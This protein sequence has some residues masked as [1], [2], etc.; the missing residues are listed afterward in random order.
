MTPDLTNLIRIG[1][2]LHFAILL[3]GALTPQ[4][5]NWKAELRK[6]H[7]MSR[8]IIWVHGVFIMLTIIGFGLIATI[9][10]PALANGRTQLA[11]G[12]C[13]FIAIFWAIRFSLQFVL[14]KPGP[15]HPAEHALGGLV[16]VGQHGQGVRCGPRPDHMATGHLFHPCPGHLPQAR[17]RRFH[18]WRGGLGSFAVTASAISHQDAATQ[19]AIRASLERRAA[20]YRTPDGLVLPVGFKIGS[21]QVV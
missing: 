18:G 9:C 15:L 20:A 1:G 12:I 13:T 8:H 6:L 16:V 5:L 14:F 4:V 11:Q 19:A 3:A 17:V 2:L 7:P 21:G 10:A